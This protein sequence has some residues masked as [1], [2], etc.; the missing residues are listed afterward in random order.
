MAENAKKKNT[1]EMEIVVD[2]GRK[3]VPIKNT[4]GE[5]IGEFYF[6]PTDIGIINR[7]DEVEQDL[8]DATEPLSNLPDDADED[9]TAKAISEAEEKLYDAVDYLFGGNASEAFFGTVSPFSP[10][11]GT[12]YCELV[13]E[14]VGDFISDQFGIENK[15]VE[16]RTD[17]YTKKYSKR[18]TA[19]PA[20]E[21]P[22]TVDTE[23]EVIE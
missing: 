6:N 18:K 5:E 11:N 1:A 3:R 7:F 8:R 16:S 12:F 20:K 14:K 22:E 21:I 23:A 9:T 15:K 2:D 4:D 13:L 19:K 10:I 17:K